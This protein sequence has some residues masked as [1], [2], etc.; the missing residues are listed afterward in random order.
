MSEAACQQ[1]PDKP[2]CTRIFEAK[3]KGVQEP[4]NLCVVVE[5]T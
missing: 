5:T 1:L 4:I 3:L 2:G